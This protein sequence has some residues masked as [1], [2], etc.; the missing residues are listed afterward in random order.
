[1]AQE[2]LNKSGLSHLW[3]IIKGYFIKKSGDTMNGALSVDNSF[4]ANSATIG[5]LVVTGNASFTNDLQGNLIGTVNGATPI[6]GGTNARS[7]VTIKPTTTDVYSM[8]ST[9]SVT[10]GTATTP[11]TID[12]SK[13]NGGSYSHS[14]FSGGSYTRG[15]FTAGSLTMAMDTT[16]TKKV[17]ITF[18]P[19]SHANDSFTPAS[20]GTD[21]FTAASLASGFYTAGTKGTPTAVTLPTRSSS[22]IKAWTGYTSG[23]NNTY[24]EAQTFTGTSC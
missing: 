17:V 23:V 11:S 15:T 7:A 16:D 9:G 19:P 10:A 20:Y 5:N 24:A 22:A 18:T 12:T 3:D 13:F 21:S 4:D 6:K 1:M 14:G 2:Y 8:T